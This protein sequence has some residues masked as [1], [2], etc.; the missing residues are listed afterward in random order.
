M[1]ESCGECER[2]LREHPGGVLCATGDRERAHGCCA[3]REQVQKMG[4]WG[5]FSCPV[6]GAGALAHPDAALVRIA[7]ARGCVGPYPCGRAIPEF[8]GRD[9]A[10][11]CERLA[12]CV[13]SPGERP[14]P[15]DPAIERIACHP[16]VIEAAREF[17]LDNHD[18]ARSVLAYDRAIAGDDL[19]NTERAVAAA[20]VIALINLEER[21]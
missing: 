13:S 10:C 3:S 7:Q 17:D 11:E 8:G 16:N 12:A 6:C 4:R 2:D 21:P 20:V 9:A 19:R 15:D 5:Q 1:A 14:M 18:L